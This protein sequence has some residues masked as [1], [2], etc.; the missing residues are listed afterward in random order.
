MTLIGLV[1][2]ALTHI[3]KIIIAEMN[4]RQEAKSW[5]LN[6]SKHKKVCK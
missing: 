3:T 5:S 2:I 4:A 1:I 6:V